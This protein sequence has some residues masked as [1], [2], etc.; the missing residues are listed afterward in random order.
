MY[1][2]SI[3]RKRCTNMRY[4]AGRTV[5]LKNDSNQS[6]LT[7]KH[8]DFHIND[9]YLRKKLRKWVIFEIV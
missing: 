8:T 2:Y 9:Q 4:F 3:M 6:I 1:G 5:Q 7:Q